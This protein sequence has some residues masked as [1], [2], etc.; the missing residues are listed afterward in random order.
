MGLF[1]VMPYHFDGEEDPYDPETNAH[2]GLSYLSTALR[3]A[4]GRVDLALAGYNGGHSA[5]S[6]P[7]AEWPSETQRYV[8]W[9]SGI[10]AD[11]YAG[12]VPSPRLEEWQRAGGAW[13]CAGTP[14]FAL[15]AP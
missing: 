6:L 14:A 1:Q 2:R 15:A 8:Y 11:V 5:I 7:P 4:Q 9:G 10:L 12:R 3:L 13:L